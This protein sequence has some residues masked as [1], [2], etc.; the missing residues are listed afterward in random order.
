MLINN[1]LKINDKWLKAA[2]IG[3]LWASIEI[4]LGSFLHNLRIP[5]A[6]TFLA[7]L[8]V[9]LLVAFN[10]IW[11]EQGLFWRSGLICALMKSI[12][13]SIIIL[14]PMI[15]IMYEALLLELFILLFGRNIFAYAIGGMFAISSILVQKIIVLLIKYGFDI[16]TVISNFYYFSL[17]LL[18]IKSLNPI[19]L[20]LLIFILYNI[21]GIIA[22][23]IGYL[24]GN[25]YV[26]S[27]KSIIS[28]NKVEFSNHK[29]ITKNN[30]KKNYSIGL[31]FLHLVLIIG[32]IIMIN[33][34][35]HYF[36]VVPAI[37]YIS[38]C[39][40][41]Y[42][43]SK[44]IIKK[45]G[46]WVQLFIISILTVIFWNGTQNAT[47]L[48]LTGI[49]AA[50]EMVVRALIVIIGFSAISVELR[51]PL[52]KA[53]MFKKGFLQLYLSLNLSFSA[54]P[55]I[56]S[57]I[58]K[59]KKVLRNPLK[60]LS[61]IVFQAD[62]LLKEFES[63]ISYNQKIYIITEDEHKGKT[64]FVKTLVSRLNN[65]GLNVHGFIAEAVIKDNKLTGYNLKN[66]KNNEKLQ[67]ITTSKHDDWLKLGPYYFNPRGFDFG[68]EILNIGNIKNADLIVIDEIGPLELAGEGWCNQINNLLAGN[69]VPMIWVVRKSII[70][71]VIK[72]WNLLNYEIFNVA[73][74]NENEVFNK[75]INIKTA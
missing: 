6:G 8:G 66:L 30:N 61:N 5:F 39:L 55:S 67:I 41:K 34:N 62:E 35:I 26:T 57:N 18:N 14:G 75:I 73:L 42:D 37:L 52:I 38:F 50:F 13:P 53:I 7:I 45:T 33:S 15:G 36:S 10:Q 70:K 28:F 43:S 11:N 48:S 9:S 23:T 22:A 21:L 56:I 54:L 47:F 31:L 44:K 3:S 17:H 4:I 46:L 2:V 25:K 59:P 40:I 49:N 27:K 1:S 51:N 68:N 32:C 58:S 64:T 72:K 19:Y 69:S 74:C 16:V 60:F 12:S 29:K 24:I 20:I 71:E 65:T 63:H